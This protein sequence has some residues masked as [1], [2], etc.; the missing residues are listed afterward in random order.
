M[1]DI[2]L[3]FKNESL[4]IS[5]CSNVLIINCG[6]FPKTNENIYYNLNF[7]IIF[8]KNYNTLNI[9]HTYYNFSYLLIDYIFVVF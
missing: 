4:I 3:D 5:N 7:K 8:Y 2:G 9:I 1:F 6:S